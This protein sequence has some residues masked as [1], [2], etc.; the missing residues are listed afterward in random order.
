MPWVFYVRLRQQV[1]DR[2]QAFFRIR[3][4]FMPGE[5]EAQRSEGSRLNFI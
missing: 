3:D 2:E 1:A 5:N 4:L